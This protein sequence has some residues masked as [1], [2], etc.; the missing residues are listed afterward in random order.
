M[1]GEALIGIFVLIF[2]G[3]RVNK[4]VVVGVGWFSNTP[5]NKKLQVLPKLSF[6]PYHFHLQLWGL[7][8]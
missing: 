3:Y 5:N 6:N 8:V 4:G 7:F 2:L 1:R